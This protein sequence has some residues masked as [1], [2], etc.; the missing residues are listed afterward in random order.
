[1]LVL[2]CT[3]VRDSRLVLWADDLPILYRAFQ[4][5]STTSTVK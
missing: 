2:L 1:V 4:T 5:F 3:S